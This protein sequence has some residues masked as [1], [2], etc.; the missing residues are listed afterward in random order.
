MKQKQEISL[1]DLSKYLLTLESSGGAAQYLLVQ[2]ETL[3]FMCN[4][5]SRCYG[6]EPNEFNDLLQE[7]VYDVEEEINLLEDVKKIIDAEQ[8]KEKKNH[9][10][11]KYQSPDAWFTP[12]HSQKT[13]HV[14]G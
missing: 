10:V 7:I 12:S 5:T 6:V 3:L 11:F 1:R 2:A 13:G 9:P 14:I 8:N 4:E